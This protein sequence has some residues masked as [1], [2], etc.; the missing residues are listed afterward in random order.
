MRSTTIKEK[1]ERFTW[2]QNEESITI[3]MPLRNVSLKNVD[4]LYTD[5]M[6][7]VNVSTVRYV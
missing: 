7:K 4:I 5:F 1:E 2:W 3:S 6:L